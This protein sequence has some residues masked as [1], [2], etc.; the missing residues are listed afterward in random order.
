MFLCGLICCSI[1][2]LNM[3]NTLS[4]ASVLCFS[5]SSLFLDNESLDL[6]N[7]PHSNKQVM[8]LSSPDVR[9]T[10]PILRSYTAINKEQPQ[11]ADLRK[12]WQK[13]GVSRLLFLN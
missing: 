1:R 10:V 3:S 6:V 11:I 13:T 9:M 2:A 8:E 4:H 12:K 7:D 5:A